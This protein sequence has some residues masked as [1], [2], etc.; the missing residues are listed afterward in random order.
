MAQILGRLMFPVLIVLILSDFITMAQNPCNGFVVMNL[1][2]ASQVWCTPH[3]YQG[4]Y[5]GLFVSTYPIYYGPNT[6]F[7]YYW[8]RG[9]IINN[10]P[11]LEL[12]PAQIGYMGTMFWSGYYEGGPATI[13]L[14][15]TYTTGTLGT[16]ADGFEVYLFITPSGWSTINPVSNY[17]IPHIV[18]G[19]FTNQ[20]N[21]IF[22]Y[23]MPNTKYIV[24][25]WD[26]V[27]SFGSSAPPPNGGDWNVWVSNGNGNSAPDVIDVVG[28]IGFGAFEPHPGDLIE[29]KVTYDPNT[30]TIIGF[31]YDLNTGQLA[32]FS[33]RL[34]G[35]FTPPSP[36]YYAFGIAANTGLDYANWGVIAVSEQGITYVT[37]IV[38]TTVTVTSVA[39]RTVTSTVTTTVTSP[40]IVTSTVT[41]VSPTTVT[42]TVIGTVTSTV[43]TTVIP[44]ATTVTVTSLS[45]ISS[46]L[47]IILTVVIAL[48]IVIVILAILLVASHRR[49]Q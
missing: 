8:S 24:V 34:N 36:G 23:A 1:T 15:G 33:Y 20:G 29:V 30:N 44:P 25:Q 13:T 45:S 22:P 43:T 41:T 32:S 38:T 7:L 12:T 37:A 3:V 18:S 46:I 48:I 49:T 16:V 9:G 39:T 42:T 26:P 17:S 5:K 6:A 47:P 27:W 14:V 35:Y 10:Q 19:N 31:A 21:V 2:L 40:V 28:G 4:D 11:V